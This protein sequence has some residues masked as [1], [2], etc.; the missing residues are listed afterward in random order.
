NLNDSL[1]EGKGAGGQVAR[2]R[3]LRSALVV[4]EVALALVL[5]VSAGLLV[6][7]FAR[8]QKIHTGFNTDN[9]LTMVLPLPGAKYREDAQV[10]S[11]FRQATERIRALPGVRS[12]GIVNYLPLYGGLGSSTGFTIEGRPLPPPGE[13][14]STNVRVSDSGYF[15]A[16]GI[17]LR[18]GRLF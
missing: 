12:V 16:M 3:R 18:R 15:E 14:P 11:F 9:I 2:S 6:R 8:L 13:E 10:I 4:V 5:L 17:P 7:S 1:K